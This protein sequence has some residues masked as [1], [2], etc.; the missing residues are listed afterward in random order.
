MRVEEEYVKTGFFWLPEQD[1][2][3]IPGII[4]IKNG[5]EIELEVV[6]LFDSNVNKLSDLN[7]PKLLN[8]IIGLIEDD[9][10]A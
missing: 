3:K 1:E 2:N 5:G 4:T 8:R 7:S 9:G 6:G 10:L